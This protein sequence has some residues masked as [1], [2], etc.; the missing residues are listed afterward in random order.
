MSR[1]AGS[2]FEV[3]AYPFFYTFGGFCVTSTIQNNING[4][5]TV[6][7]SQTRYGKRESITGIAN[8][9][10]PALFNVTFPQVPI[11]RAES[12]Y[13][14]IDTDYTNY[15]VVY[16]CRDILYY[17]AVN[18]WILSRTAILDYSFLVKAYAALNN[19]NIPTSHLRLTI[20]N[21]NILERKLNDD[22]EDTKT[23]VTHSDHCT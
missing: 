11:A 3:L 13:Y 6:T 8:V 10:S 15:A 23:N 21:C 2:W 22:G 17:N 9:I 19:Q 16:A 5:F 20:Q 7:N 1:Y 4:S 12:N 14:V 18:V